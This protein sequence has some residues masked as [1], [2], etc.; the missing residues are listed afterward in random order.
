MFAEKLPALPLRRRS[1]LP[2]DAGLQPQA[3]A[4]PA[5]AAPKEAL[6]ALGADVADAD[7]LGLWTVCFC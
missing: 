7:G 2:H 3:E 1:A 5:R 4:A 6:Q